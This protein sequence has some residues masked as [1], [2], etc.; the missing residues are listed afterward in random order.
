MPEESSE[1]GVI[2]TSRFYRLPGRSGIR[3]PTGIDVVTEGYIQGGVIEAD[4]RTFG[5]SLT[6]PRGDIE[7]RRLLLDPE[8]FERFLQELPQYEA[9]ADG[10][11]T[12]SAMWR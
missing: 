12:R 2:Y 3:R 11:L 4:N 9:F 6:V 5:T 10:P 8:K 1:S 7:L